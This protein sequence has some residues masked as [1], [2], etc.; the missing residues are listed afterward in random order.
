MAI[1]TNLPDLTP[2]SQRFKQ[3]IILPSGGFSNPIAFPG[4]KFIVYPWDMATSEWMVTAPRTNELTYMVQ[5]V[6][7]LS[8]LSTEVVKTMV[9]SELPLIVMVARALTFPDSKVEY[10]ATCP[11]CRT[12]Q[13]K[14]ALQIP[15]ALQK[16]SEKPAGYTCDT[17]TLPVSKDVIT[18]K[19]ATVTE[20][21]AAR[22]RPEKF[23]K[24]LGNAEASALAAVRTVG[25]GVPDTQDELVKWY[26]ALSPTDSEFLV[27]EIAKLNPGVSTSIKH[28]CDNQACQREFTYELNLTTDFFRG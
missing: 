14:V 7:R 28:V 22:N 5:L 6:S 9:S 15:N 23:Q 16:I 13:A 3:E 8:H 10:V 24:V 4:G 12:N 25:G 19:P 18:V 20:Q 11:Y 27:T 2:A 17:V 26:R 21:E 1:K